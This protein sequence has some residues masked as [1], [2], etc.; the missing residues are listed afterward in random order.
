MSVHRACECVWLCR[1]GYYR[2]PMHWTIRDAELI[3]ALAKLVEGRPNRG[4]WMCRKH[5][6][7]QGRPW[8]HKRIYR[9]YKLMRLNLRRQ[10]QA[11]QARAGR[12]LRTSTPRYGLV[13]R[14]HE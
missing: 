7:R 10:A 9:V 8:N 2:Q 13:C 11:T 12:A 3:A 6:R 1:S 4:F 5:L 14:F